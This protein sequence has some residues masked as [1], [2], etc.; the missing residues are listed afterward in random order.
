[1][2]YPFFVKSRSDAPLF[3][4]RLNDAL[5]AAAISPSKLINVLTPVKI[6]CC[7]H[8]H[9]HVELPG[10]L[11]ATVHIGSRCVCSAHHSCIWKAAVNWASIRFLPTANRQFQV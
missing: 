7:V 2:V 10:H 5:P 11:F 3:C 6:V 9:G 1:M 4:Y 8:M